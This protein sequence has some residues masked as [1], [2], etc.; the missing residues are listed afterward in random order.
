[1]SVVFGE[2]EQDP[3]PSVTELL[4]TVQIWAAASPNGMQAISRANAIGMTTESSQ[5]KQWP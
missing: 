3:L 1:L 2:I 5:G 4:E